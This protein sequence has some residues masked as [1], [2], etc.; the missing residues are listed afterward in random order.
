MKRIL[1]D[2]HVLIWWMCGDKEF[3]DYEVQLLDGEL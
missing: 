2:T 1:I 3:S